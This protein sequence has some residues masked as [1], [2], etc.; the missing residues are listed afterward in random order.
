VCDL[1]I[2]EVR[3]VAG[4]RL[5]DQLAECAE[6]ESTRDI[7]FFSLIPTLMRLLMISA[8]RNYNSLTSV[9]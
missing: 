4:M 8:I 9:A 3:V 6:F 5:D 2:T 7:D 1:E